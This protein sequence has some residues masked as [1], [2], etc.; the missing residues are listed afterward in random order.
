VP[1]LATLVESYDLFL[2]DAFGV[3]VNA[4]GALPG[5]IEMLNAI[6]AAGKRFRVVTNDAS[7]LPESAAARYQR[8][9]LDIQPAS[10][11]SSGMLLAAYFESNNLRGARCLV[12]GPADSEEYVARAGG[13]VVKATD[14]GDYDA[15]IVCDDA[16]YPFLGTLDVVIS[17]LFRLFDSGRAPALV[18]PNPDIVY[19]KG[20]SSYGFTA[21]GA[22][23]LLETA[24]ARRYPTQPRFVPL[25]KPEPMLFDAAVDGADRRRVLMVGDQLET[26]IAGASAANIDSLLVESGVSGATTAS[27][28]PTLRVP[29]LADLMS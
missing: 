4:E 17:V 16:G 3:L 14:D 5:A 2:L 9:G 22:A 12:L 1:K 24:L 13:E 28:A 15:V 20:S 29:R 27:V 18:L 6:A 10:I 7:N 21:G 25:G 8:Y 19:P 11:L 26:D 23:L